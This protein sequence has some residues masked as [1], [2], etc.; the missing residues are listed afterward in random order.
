[1][2]GSQEITEANF[3]TF[4]N[5]SE[6]S[7]KTSAFLKI[8]LNPFVCIDATPWIILASQEIRGGTSK[9]IDVAFN[10]AEGAQTTF[11]KNQENHEFS[12]MAH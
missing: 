3:S 7:C 9:V 2:S 11:M 1:M 4:E 12:K 5:P 6:G 8:H 10:S